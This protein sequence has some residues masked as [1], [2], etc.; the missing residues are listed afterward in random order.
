MLSPSG[1]WLLPMTFILASIGLNILAHA[2]VNPADTFYFEESYGFIKTTLNYS[3]VHQ[4]LNTAAHMFAL[5]HVNNSGLDYT[6]RQS[7]SRLILQRLTTALK[8]TDK[9]VQV[10]P[11]S[12]FYGTSLYDEVYQK[13][14]PLEFVSD[15]S[16]YLFGIPSANQY[17]KTVQ[18]L[19][20]M[21]ATET[22]RWETTKNSMLDVA[23]LSTIVQHHSH[24]FSILEAKINHLSDLTAR[25]NYMPL[26]KWRQWSYEMES[27][28]L[29]NAATDLHMDIIDQFLNVYYQAIDKAS[30]GLLSTRLLPPTELKRLLLQKVTP[31]ELFIPFVGNLDFFYGTRLHAMYRTEDSIISMLRI[32]YVHREPYSSHSLT[33]F[34]FHHPLNI[35]YVLVSNQGFRYLTDADHARCLDGPYGRKKICHNRKLNIL[36]EYRNK[37]IVH[38]FS[39]TSIIV[40]LR[41]PLTATITCPHA[42]IQ[43]F[44]I[45]NP[46]NITLRADCTMSTKAF[47]IWPTSHLPILPP[48][49]YFTHLVENLPDFRSVFDI[50]DDNER[51]DRQYYKDL[52]HLRAQIFADTHVTL[53]SDDAEFIALNSSLLHSDFIAKAADSLGQLSHSQVQE[54]SLSVAQNTWT[55]WVPAL[56][57]TGIFI[58]ILCVLHRFGILYT[59]SVYLCFRPCKS[60]TVQE[61]TIQLIESTSAAELRK[62]FDAFKKQTNLSIALLRNTINVQPQN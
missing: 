12:S 55:I 28:T 19:E 49:Q 8:E 29:E 22:K 42:R 27:I 7:H 51:A 10:F 44:E 25:D 21:Q 15:V 16:Q 45:E 6:P 59:I 31:S 58:A 5:R 47:K 14:A 26:D 62:E 4:N 3:L 24:D 43:T 39:L 61:R 57:F 38:D 20:S 50:V 33:P 48:Q 60:S 40:D 2:H 37:I 34:E 1:V 46:V 36:P 41:A 32:P 9:L 35:R 53:E 18:T 52:K 30:S 56:A 23:H 54:L 17:R 13:R 11:L